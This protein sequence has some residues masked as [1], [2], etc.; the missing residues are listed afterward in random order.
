MRVTKLIR[1]YVEKTVREKMPNPE[2]PVDV[3]SEEYEKLIEDLDRHCR[4]AIKEFVYK[5]KGEFSFSWSG[6]TADDVERQ[7][8]HVDKNVG[9][10]YSSINPVAIAEYNKACKEIGNKRQAVVEDILVSLELSANRAELEEML[11]KIR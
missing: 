2:K 8:A 1:E 3:I 9:L 11:S 10:H 4:D 7:I 6:S 5:H